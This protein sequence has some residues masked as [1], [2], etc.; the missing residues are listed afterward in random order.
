MRYYIVAG[1]ASGDLHASNLIKAIRQLDPT[2][3]F[4]GCGGD[5]MRDAGAEL[6]LHY[7]DMA[8][9]GFWEVFVH[10]KAVLGN[11]K[12]C[13]TDIMAWA[14]DVLVLVD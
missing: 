1:E 5:F 10:L 3:E 14:P 6:L 8:F 9:M 12:R 2:A 7:K 13:K 11:I 4:R